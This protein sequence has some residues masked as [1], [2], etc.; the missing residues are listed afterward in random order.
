LRLN[1]PYP[2]RIQTLLL[3]HPPLEF[4]RKRFF[5]MYLLKPRYTVFAMLVQK[6][7][8]DGKI[9]HMETGATP[10]K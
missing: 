3:I 8:K 2:A 1:Y 5:N 9:I 7:L 4:E 6:P 10:I